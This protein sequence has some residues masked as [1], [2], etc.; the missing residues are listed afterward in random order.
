MPQRGLMEWVTHWDEEVKAELPSGQGQWDSQNYT[1]DSGEFYL[2]RS[3][4]G[5]FGRLA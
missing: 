5:V 2:Y 3:F 1:R 4:F